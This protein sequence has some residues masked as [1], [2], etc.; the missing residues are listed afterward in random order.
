LGVFQQ[1][2]TPRLR[3]SR[4][5][6]GN[7]LS[8]GLQVLQ[9]YPHGTRIRQQIDANSVSHAFCI[10]QIQP[11]APALPIKIVFNHQKLN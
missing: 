7:L 9:P 4:Q 2:V 3:P 6:R 5:W 11:N 1:F 8:E 10:D